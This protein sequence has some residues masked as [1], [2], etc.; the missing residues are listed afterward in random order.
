MS[1]RPKDERPE[2]GGAGGPEIPGRRYARSGPARAC[3]RLRRAPD[4][5]AGPGYQG[6]SVYPSLWN[7]WRAVMA[8]RPTSTPGRSSDR[9]T[10][11]APAV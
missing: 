6:L 3:A 10:P 8:E 9:S 2:G 7:Q 4:S 1:G 5:S 11:R